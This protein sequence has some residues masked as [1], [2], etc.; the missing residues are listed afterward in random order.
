[1]SRGRINEAL[2]GYATIF[3][4]LTKLVTISLTVVRLS[5]REITMF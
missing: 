2:Y 5:M 4:I 1:M 3:M